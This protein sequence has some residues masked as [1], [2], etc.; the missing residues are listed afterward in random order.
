MQADLNSGP[1]KLGNGYLAWYA[2][3]LVRILTYKNSGKIEVEE[4]T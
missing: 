3:S 1:Y 2:E 4:Q